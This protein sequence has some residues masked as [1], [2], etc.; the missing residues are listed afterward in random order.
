MKEWLGQNK[1]TTQLPPRP[2]EEIEDEN[3]IPTP[4]FDAWAKTAISSQSDEEVYKEFQHEVMMNKS[5]KASFKYLVF[6]CCFFVFCQ[7]LS[8]WKLCCKLF[9]SCC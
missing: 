3:S 9:C 7:K 6:L 8:R 1:T 4:S 2:T 5:N